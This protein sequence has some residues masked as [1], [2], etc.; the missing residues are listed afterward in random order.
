MKR[1]LIIEDEKPAARR[2]AAMVQHVMP[3]AE[4]LGPL[5]SI[6]SSIEW[7]HSHLSPDLVF[8]DIQLSDGLSFMLF[9]KINLRCPVIFTTAFDEYA[10]QAF[11]VSA[12]DYLLKPIEAHLLVEALERFKNL[13]TSFQPPDYSFLLS[14][15]AKNEVAVE[16]RLL[17]RKGEQYVPLTASQI[18][19]V[20]AEDKYVWIVRQDGERFLSDDTLEKLESKLSSHRFFRVNRRY[21][22]NFEAIA[23]IHTYFNSRLKIE[24]KPTQK[25]DIVVSRDRVSEFKLWLNQ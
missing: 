2:L 14:H 7:F 1:I 25:D 19:Y 23:K 24:L 6:E 11:R 15:Y 5:D 20:F 21:L 16:P 3:E 17:M 8:M 12:L 18:A 9:Q 10:L 4:L 22:V 13:K